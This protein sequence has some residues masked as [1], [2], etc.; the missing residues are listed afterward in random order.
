MQINKKKEKLVKN[1]T[2]LPEGQARP[3]ASAT[4]FLRE[5]CWG[6]RSWGPWNTGLQARASLWPKS[7][8][9]PQA[10]TVVLLCG[11]SIKE[12]ICSGDALE[13][14]LKLV[15]RTGCQHQPYLLEKSK[16][17]KIYLSKHNAWKLVPVFLVKYSFFSGKLGQGTCVCGTDAKIKCPLFRATR[18]TSA[19]CRNFPTSWSPV[20]KMWKQYRLKQEEAFGRIA[21]YRIY[22]VPYR[23]SH[24]LHLCH[25]RGFRR[26]PTCL[27]RS[28]LP[29]ETWVHR[30]LNVWCLRMKRCI[31]TK[32]DKTQAK[33]ECIFRKDRC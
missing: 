22:D 19:L 26:Q 6:D 21:L 8:T 32:R 15:S 3:K 17:C 30:K 2:Y 14:A 9:P 33:T 16:S 23:V 31:V 7:S 20:G 1:P 4:P 10:E 13:V 24:Q 25:W 5:I 28:A 18:P 27:G 29:G 11:E 12:C